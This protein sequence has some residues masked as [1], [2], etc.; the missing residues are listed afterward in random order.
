MNPILITGAGG[1]IAARTLEHLLKRG[2]RVVAWVRKE[3]DRTRLLHK[4]SENLDVVV[5]DLTRE[6]EVRD[7]V[8]RLPVPPGGWIHLAGMYRGGAF[9]ETPPEHLRTLM[10]VNVE[11]LVIPLKALLPLWLASEA[12]RPVQVV[13]V[14]AGSGLEGAA[15]SPFY[16]ASKAA[17]RVLVRSLDQAYAQRG[18]RFGILHLMHPADTEANATLSPDIPRIPLSSLAHTLVLWVEGNLGHL[19]E[20][21]LYA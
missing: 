2:H 3:E 4:F 6:D 11:T 7:G 17:L 15:G 18:V 8:Q 10:Q 21:N 20:L 1:Q 9:H 13:T 5:A 19:Q 14:G 12:H 16:A